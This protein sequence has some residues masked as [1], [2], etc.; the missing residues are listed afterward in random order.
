MEFFIPITLSSSIILAITVLFLILRFLRVNLPGAIDP[1]HVVITGG[2][3][4][5]GFAL[6]KEIN[7]K[8]PGCKITIVARNEKKLREAADQL[9]NCEI[10]SLDMT[11][12]PEKVI[13]ELQKLQ[14][15]DVLVCNAGNAVS[16]RFEDIDIS[17]FKKQI[18]LNYF[19]CVIPAKA[20]IAEFKKR[21]SGRICFVS[22]VA[23]Q[24]GVWGFTAYSGSKFAVVGL[25]Q[26]LAS[27]L[28]PFNIGVT[29]CYP[30]DMDT[31]GLQEENKTKPWE[32]QKISETAGLVQ[33]ETVA[34]TLWKDIMVGNFFS[35]SG[36]DAWLSTVM[37]IGW[38][39]S[40]GVFQSF[41]EVVLGGVL[42]LGNLGYMKYFD[43]IAKKG[44][45]MREK[46][47]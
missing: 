41:L 10:L 39:P 25:S 45:D 22:S 32:C 19:G 9:S 38:A 20:L 34:A 36:L 33:P 14:P 40:T 15:V 3:S 42:R 11:D 12:D 4:G 31:P 28:R 43:Y 1:K 2:S 8:S 29:V 44:R 27:E 46:T 6:A 24:L 13:N 23:G 17:T 7:K 5:L 47:E 16:G 37:S 35:A 26:A 30:P 21:E 18:D